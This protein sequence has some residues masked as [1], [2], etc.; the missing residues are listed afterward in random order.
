MLIVVA[1]V[2]VNR[3]SPR[4]KN[5]FIR[6]DTL[7]WPRNTEMGVIGTLAETVTATGYHSLGDCLDASVAEKSQP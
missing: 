6:A 3:V 1:A 7:G 5:N 4:N 2:N